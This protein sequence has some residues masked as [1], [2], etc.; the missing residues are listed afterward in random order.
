MV[1][2]KCPIQNGAELW[3]PVTGLSVTAKA[4]FSGRNSTQKTLGTRLSFHSTKTKTRV[5]KPVTFAIAYL[6]LTRKVKIR[7]FE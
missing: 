2:A 5:L 3:T 1:L 6:I 7:S 4:S